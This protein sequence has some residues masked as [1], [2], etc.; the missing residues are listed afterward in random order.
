MPFA[1]GR[2]GNPAGRP[3][4]ARHKTTIAA[5]ALL[6]GEAEALTRKAIEAALGGDMTALRLCLDRILPPRRERPIK[7]ELPPL[8]SAEGASAAMAAITA[9]VAA[10][11]LSLGEAESAAKLVELYLRTLE[12][13][14][15]ERRLRAL[16]QAANAKKR[17]PHDASRL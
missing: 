3:V 15:Y 12:T 5:E 8:R 16:E 9:A 4:G 1:K 13:A 11:E 10:G 6:D 14:E 17:R 7:F 2:S